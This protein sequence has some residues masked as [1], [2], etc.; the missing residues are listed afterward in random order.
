MEPTPSPPPI[1]GARN[2]RDYNIIRLFKAPEDC[3]D[4]VVEDLLL[5]DLSNNSEPIQIL[6]N[7]NG[8]CTSAAFS[9]IDVINYIRPRNQIITVG[10]G[11]ICSAGLDI[12]LAG[13]VRKLTRRASILSHHFIW[14][15][16]GMSYPELL[17]R[18]KEEDLLAERCIDWYMERTGLSRE[19]VMK[20]LLKDHD[21]WLSAEE[22]LRL[23]IATEIL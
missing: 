17:A 13:D 20:F 19:D 9:I 21:A 3:V 7:C 1:I 14:G 2:L 10:I 23:N 8:G 18:R 5:I 11:D 6:I 12:F 22:A 4:Q 16:T 15:N